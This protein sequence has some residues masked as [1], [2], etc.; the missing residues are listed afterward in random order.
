MAWTDL[1]R[2]LAALLFVLSLMGGLALVL[3]KTGLA[4]G[5]VLTSGK[6]R[7]KILETLPLDARRKMV[8]VQRDDK[9]HLI[10]LG[11]NSDSVIE[12]GIKTNDEA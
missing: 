1:L 12:T 2:F 9:Q 10:L 11:P 8:L 6:K 7:L 3:K 4:T 5:A